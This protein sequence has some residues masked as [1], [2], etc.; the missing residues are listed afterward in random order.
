MNQQNVDNPTNKNAS[1]VFI[2]TNIIY[3]VIIFW[4]WI[5]KD[6]T[7]KL[8]EKEQYLKLISNKFNLKPGLLLQQGLKLLL[9]Q[10]WFQANF[11]AREGQ[12]GPGQVFAFSTW[13]SEC[14]N[15]W[16]NESSKLDNVLH[17]TSSIFVGSMKYVAN[18][19]WYQCLISKITLI[20][21]VWN[22]ETVLWFFC[23]KMRIPCMIIQIDV[24]YSRN[25]S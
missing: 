23:V 6:K 24:T 1:T 7:L 18:I 12:W 20:I 3:L 17:Q 22:M 5:F 25:W 21:A 15:C 19:K 4:N 10:C 13:D 11:D 8:E 14:F 16:C 9:Q 2:Q